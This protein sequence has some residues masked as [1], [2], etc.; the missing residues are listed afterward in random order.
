MTNSGDPLK[1]PAT[2]ELIFHAALT[3]RDWRAVEAALHLL[4]VV[5]PRRCAD[6]VHLTKIALTIAEAS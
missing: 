1:D 5:D 6:L 4:A 2:L 3:D